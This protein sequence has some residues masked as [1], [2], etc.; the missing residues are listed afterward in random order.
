MA[1]LYAKLLILDNSSNVTY[2]GSTS[3]GLFVW[4]AQM[5]F[6]PYFQETSQDFHNFRYIRTT[7]SEASFIGLRFG[8]NPTTDVA[9]VT[10]SAKYVYGIRFGSYG[11]G[12]VKDNSDINTVYNSYGLLR[13]TNYVG[14]DYIAEDYVGESRVLTY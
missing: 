1:T 11:D 8:S 2:A 9:P 3:N 4:G 10:D 7:G 12:R 5:E 14:I 13:M 6:T